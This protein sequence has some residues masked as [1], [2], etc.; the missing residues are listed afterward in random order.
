MVF[1]FQI[2]EKFN[3]MYLSIDDS[4]HVTHS[5]IN[6]STNFV[7][8]SPESPFLPLSVTFWLIFT[9]TFDGTLIKLFYRRFMVMLNIGIKSRV[10]GISIG[11]K[12]GN[13]VSISR[14]IRSPFSIST[15][16][17]DIINFCSKSNT[18]VLY[19]NLK[20]KKNQ[21]FGEVAPWYAS[22]AKS[23]LFLARLR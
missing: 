20:L 21:W 1:D 11:T 14:V 4:R 19:L 13:F 12:F 16:N 15:R 6:K 23:V 10:L 9:T 7:P 8:C 22:H 5:R 3:L 18:A 17:F 2:E